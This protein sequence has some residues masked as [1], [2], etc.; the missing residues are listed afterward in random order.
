MPGAGSPSRP[1]N[2]TDVLE[3][4]GLERLPES[5]KQIAHACAD[6]PSR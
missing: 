3:E 2:Y 5:L 1:K 6:L 4:L